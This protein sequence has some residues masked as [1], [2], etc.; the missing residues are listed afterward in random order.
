MATPRN[1]TA[2]PYR[3]HAF[4]RSGFGEVVGSAHPEEL[5]LFDQ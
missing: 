3:F 5:S 4:E 2:S 1:A